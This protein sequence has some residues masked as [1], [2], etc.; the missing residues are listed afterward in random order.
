MPA[1]TASVGKRCAN[2]AAD[3]EIVQ[4]L[5]N[6][7]IGRMSPLR[8]VRVSGFCDPRTLELIEEFQRRVLHDEQ[9]DGRVEPDGRVMWAL[10]AQVPAGEPT[11]DGVALPAPAAQALLAALKKVGLSTATITSASRTPAEQARVMYENCVKH[12]AAHGKALYGAAGDKVI[13]VYSR[14]KDKPKDEVIELMRKKIEELGPARVSRHLSST[15]YVFDVD[16]ASIP[17]TK[18]KAFVSALR[19]QKAVSKVLG[20]PADPA[21]H[22][23][24]PRKP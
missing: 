20:P 23:E 21:F 13:D 3:V 8:P 4:E 19:A 14:S 6:R 7:C 15:H 1:I 16:P 11:L 18:H 10:N 22:I 12:G 9:P 2:R 5:L 24:M 17:S